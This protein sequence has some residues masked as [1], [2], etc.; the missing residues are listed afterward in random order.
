MIDEFERLLSIE[1]DP[2]LLAPPKPE[3]PEAPRDWSGLF[4]RGVELVKRIVPELCTTPLYVVAMDQTDYFNGCIGAMTGPHLDLALK[5]LIAD[6]WRG[7]GVAVVVNST[8]AEE[9]FCWPGVAELFLIGR[10]ILH[11]AGHAVAEGWAL[12]RAAERDDHPPEA[13][14][15]LEKI[16][17]AGTEINWY[18]DLDTGGDTGREFLAHDD[19]WL[20]CCC[21]LAAR[22]G[23]EAYAVIGGRDDLSAPEKYAAALGDETTLMAAAPLKTILDSEPPDAFL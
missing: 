16:T 4:A 19:R 18:D 11:E 13:L 7:R 17:K 14:T 9:Y 1:P 10:L 20:R 22:A 5:S 23:V 3:T 6:G 8:L 21:H 15:L 2:S 12:T